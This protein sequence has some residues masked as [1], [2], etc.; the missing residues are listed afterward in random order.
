MATVEQVTGLRRDEPRGRWVLLA[1]V[2][3]S[4]MAFL[5]GTV[6]N[7]ALPAI[8]RDL[9]ADL[10]G[11]QWTINAYTLT[12]AAFIL[13]GGA[14]GDRFGRRRV[15]VI[16]VVWF[17]AGSLACGL[18]PGIG[19]L[20]A[21]R[22]FQ[23]VGAALLTPGSLALLQASFRKEDRGRVIGSWSGLSGIAAALGPVLGGWLVQSASWRWAFL[24][25]V[26]IAV[27]VALVAIRHVP[28]TFDPSAG[29]RFDV[30]GALLCAV[31]L[32]AVTFGLVAWGGDGSSG[33]VWGSVLL[34]VVAAVAFIQVERTSSEPM[35]PLGIF[36]SGLFRAVNLVTFAVYAALSGVF[37]MLVI[38]LQLLAGFSPT[39]AGAALLPV[40][41]LM[42]VLSGPAGS[43]GQR[44]GP[45]L[46]LTLGPLLSTAGTLLLV[47]VDSTASYLT[48]V[49]PGVALFGL[50]LSVTVAPLTATVL[51]AA[52]LR[53]AGLASGVNNAVARS[54]GLLIVA[55][56][57]G[58]VGLSSATFG[59]AAS[60]QTGYSRAML[61]CAALLAVGAG[62]G[63]VLIRPHRREAP[64]G[65]EAVELALPVSPC[66]VHCAVGGPPLQ[67]ESADETA[68]T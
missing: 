16:G 7:V 59:E 13:L 15:F 41:G 39:A 30:L 32:G 37:F 6:V 33:V 2:L 45:R 12:L 20:V 63:A 65:G 5:D 29:R 36:G 55:A 56:L 35:L 27:V 43:L 53:H 9:G 3:G 21:A 47:R 58:A 49:L 44:T 42:L 68:A 51:A 60:L 25:N 50:G 18:A 22:A 1:T 11:L 48:D 46:P 40:T 66:R 62:L 64:G 52:P 8:G 17:A 24:I 23:G 19:T 57:P 34:G 10:A 38:T 4:G 61:V 67:P 26:P 28:E 54:A 31:A 14:A